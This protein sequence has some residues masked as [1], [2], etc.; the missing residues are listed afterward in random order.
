MRVELGFDNSLCLVDI[1]RLELRITGFTD[2]D[3]RNVLR[4]DSEIAFWREHR[5]SGSIVGASQAVYQRPPLLR[6]SRPFRPPSVR[7]G[8]RRA[9]L[10]SSLRPW[11]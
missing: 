2:A 4:H 7:S 9:S 5:L 10:T 3:Y 1:E 6:R 11:N 8:P